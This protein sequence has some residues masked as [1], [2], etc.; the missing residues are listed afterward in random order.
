MKYNG[1]FITIEGVEGA[2]K[3]TQ[4]RLLAEA[5]NDN[6]IVTRE[7][8]GTPISEKV[9]E[10]FLSD[11]TI[12]ATTELLL[13]GAARTQHVTELILPALEDGKTVI[14]DR[15]SDATIAYQG[16]RKGID[17]KLVEQVNDIATNGLIPDV[18]FL[19]DL[20]PE[21]GLQ[22]KQ[23]SSEPLTRLEFET[24]TQHEKV[25]EGY[26][27]VANAQPERVLV[28]DARLDVNIIHHKLL[29]EIKNR[30]QFRNVK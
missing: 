13:I 19:L 16:Y 3:T 25:R 2:G 21:L 15:F 8:G 1:Y 14:C 30:L 10:L 4:I 29:S 24:I 17:L 23:D 7:P 5:L 27:S 22:R 18:T 28:I 26:L 12:S 6:V 9:R 11:D 20:P